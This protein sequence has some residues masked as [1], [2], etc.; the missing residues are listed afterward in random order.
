MIRFRSARVLVVMALLSSSGVVAAS[1]AIADRRPSARTPGAVVAGSEAIFGGDL[2]A[3]FGA[4][5]AASDGSFEQGPPPGSEWSEVINT[6]TNCPSGIWDWSDPSALGAAAPDG[7][8][9]FWAGGYCPGPTDVGAV[10]GW[11]EQDVTV[12]ASAPVLIFWYAAFRDDPAESA[13]SDVAFVDINGFEQWSVD[14]STA[15]NDTDDG[16]GNRCFVP[17]RLDLGAFAGQVVELR[18]G[19][20]SDLSE[21]VGNVFFDDF[22]FADLVS[23]DGFECGLGRWSATTP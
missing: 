19:L 14:V 11:V 20:D 18:V 23:A 6:P 17:A 21:L 2:S 15:A 5:I 8:M 4:G 16:A 10:E 22:T 13:G 1:A 9:S 12:P 3:G 7:T